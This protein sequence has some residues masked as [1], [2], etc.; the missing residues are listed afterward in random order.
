MRLG[1][2][3]IVV[4]AFVLVAC[5]GENGG[6]GPT[7]PSEFP[8]VAGI[9]FI[10]QAIINTNCP[11]VIPQQPFVGAITQSGSQIQM[12]VEIVGL[13]GN[14]QYTGTIQTNGDFNISQTTTFPEIGSRTQSTVSG[15]FSGGSLSATEDETLTD[16]ATGLGCLVQW[17][18]TGNL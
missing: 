3:S 9:W 13:T 6:S 5:G 4:V 8:G 11:G 15:R 14:V 1:A 18:W 7:A 12:T 2:G 10:D 16:L 17:R